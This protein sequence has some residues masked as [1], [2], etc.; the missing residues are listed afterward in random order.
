MY[1]SYGYLD[2]VTFNGTVVY[3]VSTMNTRGQTTAA[4]I[5]GTSASWGYNAYGQLTSSAASGVQGYSYSPNTTTGN[6]TSRT[7]SLKSLSETFYYDN[8]DR[9]GSVSGPGGSLNIG[10]DSISNLIYKSDAGSFF[11]DNGKPYQLSNVIPPANFPEIPQNIN[12][13]AFGKISS[14]SEGVNSATFKYNS[15]KQRVKMSFT[16]SGPGFWTKYYFGSSYE[17]VVEAYTTTE[18]IWIGG[19]PYTA[20]AVAKIV[21]G[22]TPQVWAIF[23]DHL[24]TITHLKNGST[25]YE[26]SFDAWGRRRDKDNWSYTLSGEPALFANRGFTGHEHLTEFGLINMNGRLYDP[27]VG[28]FLS[29]D[30]YVQSPDF[31]QNFNRYGYCLNNPLRYT[32]PDGDWFLIDDAAEFVIGGTINLLMNADKVDNFWEGL[33]YFAS[34]G[35]GAWVAIQS[36]GL[37]APAGAAIASFGNSMLETNFL[38]EENNFS[39]KSINNKEWGT[40]GKSTVIGAGA[41]LIGGWAGDKLSNGLINK[42]GIKTTFWQNATK[43]MSSMSIGMSLEFYANSTWIDGNKMYSKEAFGQLGI[44]FGS[45]LVVGFANTY[46]VEKWAKPELENFNGFLSV[47]KTQVWNNMNNSYNPLITPYPLITPPA[48]KPIWL[49]NFND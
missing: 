33:G 13:T 17:K 2:Q 38:T 40:I 43:S 25:I 21:N 12:Y 44:G 35:A 23:R 11:Y 20:V 37:A 3:D 42:F 18:Y 48:P 31:T 29:P 34:G 30:N 1:N 16:T 15:D 22:G 8:L 49:P 39:L 46:L 19:S 4:S 7:N 41:G 28:R 36:F 9:L 24:G 6:M 45:G 26:Y 27:L 14:I 5:G 32:D 10:Y 47:K